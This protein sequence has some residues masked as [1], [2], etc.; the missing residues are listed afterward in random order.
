MHPTSEVVINIFLIPF[1]PNYAKRTAKIQLYSLD[2]NILQLKLIRYISDHS[3][4]PKNS[5]FYI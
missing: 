5:V 3:L 2:Y 4:H 1:L